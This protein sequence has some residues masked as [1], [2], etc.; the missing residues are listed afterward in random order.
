MQS[1]DFVLWKEVLGDAPTTHLRLVIGPDNIP[2][3]TSHLLLYKIDDRTKQE[4]FLGSSA[5][6]VIYPFGEDIAVYKSFTHFCL[7]KY[8]LPLSNKEFIK[9]KQLLKEAKNF[10]E[11]A[12]S[13]KEIEG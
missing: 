13:I 8:D 1:K 6:T 9:A 2:G 3:Q 4:E 7:P 5:V 12:F 10:L 11:D